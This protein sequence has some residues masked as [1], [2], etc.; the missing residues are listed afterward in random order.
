V[1]VS[2]QSTESLGRLQY[3]GG[4]PA[5]CH[6]SILPSFQCGRRSRCRLDVRLRGEARR[7][8]VNIAKLPEFCKRLPKLAVNISLNSVGRRSAQLAIS[9]CGSVPWLLTHSGQAA[10][11][12]QKP[13]NGPASRKTSMIGAPVQPIPLGNRWRD[14]S[15]SNPQLRLACRD[16][17]SEP[18]HGE[19][20]N[21]VIRM[22]GRP[23]S[24]RHVSRV[25][26]AL[27]GNTIMR[28]T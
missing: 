18:R 1:L 17:S 3:A 15:A 4:G 7:I 25:F 12:K 10:D 27:T 21:H 8:A 9:A 28:Q 2:F 16:P 20:P 6:R 5:Q 26:V 23:N 14:S 19:S 22:I 24:S 11:V 13:S